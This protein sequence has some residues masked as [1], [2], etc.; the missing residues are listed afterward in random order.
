MAENYYVLRQMSE[1]EKEYR[2]AL[3]QRPDIPGLH[4]ELGQVYAGAAQWAKAEYEFRS[5]AKLQPGNAEAAYRLGAALLQQ[6]NVHE[7][8]A[9]LKRF[10]RLKTEMP[11]TR[12]SMAYA[13][14]P[15]TPQFL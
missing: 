5:E 8:R 1:A 12:Y 6:G 7:A 4:L 11:D 15:D 3:K 13:A 9:G 2:E 10:D 14:S